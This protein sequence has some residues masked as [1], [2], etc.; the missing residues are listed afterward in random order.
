[1]SFEIDHANANHIGITLTSPTGTEVR[2]ITPFT[3]ASI[4]PNNYSF[5][6][7][8]SGLYGES[9]EG[10]WTLSVTDYTDD[11]VGG[12]MKSFTIKIFGH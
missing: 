9:A 3:D 5:D 10:E 12:T 2:V 4:N 7:G 11:S 1:M 8:V 6:V